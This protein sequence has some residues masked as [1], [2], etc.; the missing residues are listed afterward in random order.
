MLPKTPATAQDL[1]IP[2]NLE[3]TCLWIYIVLDRLKQCLALRL[4]SWFS[5]DKQ[6]QRTDLDR[7]CRAV[8]Q[9]AFRG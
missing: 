4:T 2:A 7:D 6:H 1:A 5:A 8:P 3:E 9:V